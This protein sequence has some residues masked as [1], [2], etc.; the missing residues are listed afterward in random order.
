MNEQSLAIFNL[1]ENHMNESF[2]I[3]LSDRSINRDKAEKYIASFVDQNVKNFVRDII[4]ITVYVKFPEFKQNLIEAFKLFKNAIGSKPFT[5]YFNN[6]KIGSECWI[7]HMLWPEIRTLN[8]EGFILKTDIV[9]NYPKDILIIDD[10]IYSGINIL[11]SIDEL[12]YFNN[13]TGNG[14]VYHLVIPYI[15]ILSMS[16]FKGLCEMACGP[17]GNIIV[18]NSK[19]MHEATDGY[20]FKIDG[21]ERIRNILGLEMLGAM[22]AIV[23]VTGCNNSQPQITAPEAGSTAAATSPANQSP[24]SRAL[25]LASWVVISSSWTATRVVLMAGRIPLNWKSPKAQ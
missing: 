24:P 7:L 25:P 14:S 20:F 17:D 8:I 2:D 21:E 11:G 3:S 4:D 18:Y 23:P 9:K 15:N 13:V 10:C 6:R 22:S 12:S 5:I 16:Q 19:Y 1:L